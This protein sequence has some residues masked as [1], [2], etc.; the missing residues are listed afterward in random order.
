MENFLFLLVVI[1][2]QLIAIKIKVPLIKIIFGIFGILLSAVV[3]SDIAYPYFNMLSFFVSFA[4]V[5][6]VPFDLR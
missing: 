3:P 6:S 1:L 2:L 4:T 5:V